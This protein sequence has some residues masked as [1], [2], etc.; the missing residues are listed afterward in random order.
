MNI[1]FEAL[2]HISTIVSLLTSVKD[3]VEKGTIQKRW[4][5]TQE[6][7]DYT[8]YKLETIKSKIKKNDFIQGVH[9]FKRDG[10]LL[11][12][13]VEVD[14]W[15]MGV[16]SANNVTYEKEQT[17]SIVNEILSSLVS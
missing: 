4:F 3:T 9:Y 17:A 16:K 8:G 5:N 7:S 1:D 14:N 6:L 15:V 12:D 10:K 2:N 11:F 13:K